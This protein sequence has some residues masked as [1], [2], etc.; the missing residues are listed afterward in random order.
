MVEPFQQTAV[1]HGN[2]DVRALATQGVR[3]CPLRLAPQL[4]RPN[5]L[6]KSVLDK[7]N[8]QSF[9]KEYLYIKKFPIIYAN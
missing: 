7:I 6:N 1:S 3:G 9:E 5:L 2:T 8:Q 4:R